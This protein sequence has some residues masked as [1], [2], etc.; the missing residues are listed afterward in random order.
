[1]FHLASTLDELLNNHL[2]IIGNQLFTQKI[3]AIALSA[4]Y[5]VYFILSVI[6]FDD[7][8][9]ER[10][11]TRQR[12]TFSSFG[13]QSSSS[14]S[15]TSTSFPRQPIRCLCLPLLITGVFLIATN[16]K[17]W[18][19]ILELQEKNSFQLYMPRCCQSCHGPMVSK[20]LKRLALQ[21]E[22]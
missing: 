3:L 1:M 22:K 21:Q 5:L 17:G 4:S 18:K 7:R 15:T 8:H 13:C 9:N 14:S 16:D 20:I 19:K 11:E 12:F 2:M 10:S 6:R